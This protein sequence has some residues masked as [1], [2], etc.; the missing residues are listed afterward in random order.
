MRFH[1]S[2]ILYSDSNVTEVYSQG[3]N[4]QYPSIASDNALA[5]PRRQAIIWTSVD[6]FHRRIYAALGGD[7]LNNKHLAH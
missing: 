6:S 5:P 7:E 1:E 3:S 2:K 4:W